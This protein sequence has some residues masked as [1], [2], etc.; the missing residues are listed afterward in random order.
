[1]QLQATAGEICCVRS[2][3]AGAGD[4]QNNA[5]QVMG[6]QLIQRETNEYDIES[7]STRKRD[8]RV[9]VYEE[10]LGFHFGPRD[11][12]TILWMAGWVVFNPPYL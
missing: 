10:A 12:F 2:L 5:L 11:F 9:G 1:M 7:E 8:S 3:V 6:C 4:D